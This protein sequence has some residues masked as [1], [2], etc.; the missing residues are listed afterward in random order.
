MIDLDWSVGL[1]ARYMADST[2]DESFAG[3]DGSSN[4]QGNREPTDSTKAAGR[5]GRWRCCSS[6]RPPPITEAV[7]GVAEDTEANAPQLGRAAVL[8]AGINSGRALELEQQEEQQARE[9]KEEEDQ[10]GEKKEGQQQQQQ[11]SPAGPR[12]W[13]G[14]TICAPGFADSAPSSAE[15]SFAVQERHIEAIG[16]LQRLGSAH[17]GYAEPPATPVPVPGAEHGLGADELRLP[18]PEPE[19]EPDH[20]LEPLPL[21]LPLPQPEPEP[22]VELEQSDMDDGASLQ[23]H[24]RTDSGVIKM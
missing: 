8:A 15:D 7:E 16:G 1:V 2:D 12:R 17:H 11:Q 18:Q 14:S 20:E 10:D 3:S 13:C 21:P 9:D 23:R 4:R 6:G 5:G 24:K 22:Q 19:M